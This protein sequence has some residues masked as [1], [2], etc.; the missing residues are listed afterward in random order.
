MQQPPLR[1]LLQQLWK[2]ISLKRRLQFSLLFAMMIVTAFAEAIS[3]G[4]VLPFLGALTAPE[5][6]FTHPILQPIISLFRLADPEQL[7]FPLTVIFVVGAILSGLMRLL[8][9]WAQTRL[10]HS[11]GADFS[12]E[13]YRRTLYQPYSVHLARNSSEVISGVSIKAN[14]VVNS[15]VMPF[16]TICSNALIMIFILFALLTIEPVIAISSF[17]GFGSIYITVTFGTRRTL[18]R[19]SQRVNNESNQVFKALQEGLG[20][21]RDVLID[22][23][24]STYVN[25]YRNSDIP[26]RRALANISI[27]SGSPRYIIEAL[28]IVLIAILAY[29]LASSSTGIKGAIPVLGAI[30]LGAQRLLPLLQQAFASWAGMRGGQ[31]S[32]FETLKLLDQALPAYVNAPL[33]SPMSFN[34]SININNLSFRYTDDTPMVLGAGLNL[35]IKKG[36]RIGLI[37]ITGSGKSTLLDIIMGLLKPSSGS[38]EVDGKSI[39][40]DNKRAWQMKIAHV[41]QSIFLTDASIAENIAF[42]VSKERIDYTRVRMA[43][44]KAQI[45]KN[46]DT[47]ERGYNTLVGERGVRLS[48]GQR[49]RIGIARAL[50][51]KAEVIVFDEATSALDNHTENAVMEALE[52][53]EDELTLIIVAHRLSTLRKCNQ[54]I[55]LHN[56]L[57]KRIG[58]YEKIISHQVQ[59]T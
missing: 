6:I 24:Q 27:I 59:F 28:G 14:H 58:T 43:A 39:T 40:E 44:Q 13:I 31:V 32:L 22:G 48:G 54:I 34:R 56:G 17:I 53:L 20:G 29:S 35:N 46:I 11:I 8:L 45:D 23:V 4:A 19:D 50:Y 21:I 51:K 26:L 41:P 3:I 1:K 55:E 49:Q 52:G 9:L 47:W 33:K 42:G 57:I 16:L 38:L 10:G 12:I 25:I 2:H 7:L 36:S 30:T 37:G 15:I 18:K 5:Q